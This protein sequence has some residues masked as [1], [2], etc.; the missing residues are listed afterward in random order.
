MNSAMKETGCESGGGVTS[1]ASRPGE[2]FGVFSPRG[3]RIRPAFRHSGEV[4]YSCVCRN[5]F[6]RGKANQ[7]SDS[8]EFFGNGL[9]PEETNNK[10]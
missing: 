8:D 3:F 2:A 4:R 1:A 7:E 6:L 5:Y 9:E 10:Q